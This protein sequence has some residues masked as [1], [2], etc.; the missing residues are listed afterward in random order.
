VFG[1]GLVLAAYGVDP[2]KTG[3]RAITT[4]RFRISEASAEQHGIVRPPI[5]TG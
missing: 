4:T 3:V 1:A 2:L 5:C